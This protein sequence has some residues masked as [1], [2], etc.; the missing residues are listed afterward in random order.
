MA[1][2]TS[3][4]RAHLAK[5]GHRA[6][7]CTATLLHAPD[8]RHVDGRIRGARQPYVRHHGGPLRDRRTHLAGEY[9]IGDIMHFPWLAPVY[10]LGLPAMM[11]RPRVVAWHERIAE[12]PA[13]QRGMAVPAD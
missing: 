7:C 13:V 10:G 6:I 3:Q 4:R 2:S 11:E 5:P 1:P 12:R 8:A 9:S